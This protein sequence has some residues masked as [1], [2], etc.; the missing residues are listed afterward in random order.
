MLINEQ[1]TDV[2]TSI[3]DM[4]RFGT[5]MAVISQANPWADIFSG[6]E[7]RVVASLVNDELAVMVDRHSDKFVALAMLPLCGVEACVDELERAVKELGMRVAIIAASI[8]GEPTISERFLLVMEK[9]AG[10]GVQLFIHP[11]SPVVGWSVREIA[12]TPLL[13]YIVDTSI[14]LTKLLLSGIL[15]RLPKLKLVFAHQGAAAPYII[16]G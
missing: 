2:D 8:D 1:F 14:A 5:D 11:S 16:G 10:L 7:A 15:D 12:F 9:A 4:D 13:G 6:R 3:R